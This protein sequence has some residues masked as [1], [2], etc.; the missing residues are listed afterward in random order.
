VNV[1]DHYWR[2]MRNRAGLSQV[3][4]YDLRHTFASHAAMSKETLPM[5]GRLLGHRNPQS[6]T[7]Y[8]H[9]YDE[10]VLDAAGQIESAIERMMVKGGPLFHDQLRRKCASTGTE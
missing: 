9:L 3:P 5:I 1:I 2:D 10:Y 8:A 7:C 6:T 4:L